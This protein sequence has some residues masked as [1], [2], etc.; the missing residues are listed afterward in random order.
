MGAWDAG[1]LP[2]N[3]GCQAAVSIGGGGGEHDYQALKPNHG[4]TKLSAVESLLSIEEQ[5]QIAPLH[6]AFVSGGDIFHNLPTKWQAVCLPQLRTHR[7][8]SISLGRHSFFCKKG[9]EWAVEAEDQEP[10]LSGHRLDPVASGRHP[11]AVQ[12]GTEP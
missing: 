4:P 7:T 3:D 8:S 1:R 12:P 5:R 11:R 6:F 9:F 10:A 2:S